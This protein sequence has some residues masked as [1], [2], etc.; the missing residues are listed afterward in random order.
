MANREITPDLVV[1]RQVGNNLVTFLGVE[2]EESD[3]GALSSEIIDHIRASSTVVVEY[4]P[5]ELAGTVYKHG[6]LGYIAQAEANR[7]GITHFFDEIGKVTAEESK[8]ISVIDPANN[9]EFFAH[10][11]GLPLTLSAGCVVA[12]ELYKNK[13]KVSRRSLIAGMS[14]GI[15]S[16]IAGVEGASWVLHRTPLKQHTKPLYREWSVN[17]KD[18]R[19]VIVSQGLEQ[20]EGTNTLVIY[21]KSHIVDGFMHYLDHPEQRKAKFNLYSKVPG[22]T[23]SIREFK[24]NSRFG[25]WEKIKESPILS[26]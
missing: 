7:A 3:K 2:H 14:L 8:A 9:L 1:Q 15:A 6:T 26:V 10:Y 24:F 5:D 12:A 11:M 17:A 16:T 19:W 21:P 4:L 13:Q 25:A 20:M 18:S 22:L 23:T